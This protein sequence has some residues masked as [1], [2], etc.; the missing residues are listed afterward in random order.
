MHEIGLCEGIL[1]SVLRRARGREVSVVRVRV[2]VLHVVDEESMA[3][4]F[5]LVAHGTEA[6]AARLEIVT[7]P[8]KVVCRDCGYDQQTFDLIVSCPRCHG[9]IGVIGGDDLVLE[10]LTYAKTA[11]PVAHGGD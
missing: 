8:V 5:S 4:G 7:V 2:G 1:D 11:A 10:S 6:A 9:H 3:Q